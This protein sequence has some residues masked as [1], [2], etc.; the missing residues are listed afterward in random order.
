MWTVRR[1]ETRDITATVSTHKPRTHDFSWAP[2]VLQ[3]TIDTDRVMVNID[4]GIIDKK[5][6]LK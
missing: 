2:D 1:A 4:T 3:S 5:P 6:K